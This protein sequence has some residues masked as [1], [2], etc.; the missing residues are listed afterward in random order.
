M[1]QSKLVRIKPYNPKRGQLLRRYVV[2]GIRFDVN[3]GWYKVD[4]E[5]AKYLAGITNG[6]DTDPE[7]PLAFDVMDEVD[8]KKLE[9]AEAAAKEPAPAAQPQDVSTGNLST[10]DLP[11]PTRVTKPPAPAPAPKPAPTPA[12]DP[13]DEPGDKPA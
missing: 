8:A 11:Q 4:A 6:G 9:A 13:L 2:S 3:R 10:A 1:A 5:L 12:A 7:A